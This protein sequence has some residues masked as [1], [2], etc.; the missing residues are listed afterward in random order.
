[1][2]AYYQALGKSKD[3]CAVSEDHFAV[4]LHVAQRIFYDMIH[5]H[6]R[7]MSCQ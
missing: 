6:H 4:E 2:S 3:T 7:I 5:D 1:M